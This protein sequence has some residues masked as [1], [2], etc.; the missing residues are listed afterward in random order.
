M[1]PQ[2]D[3]PIVVGAG[4]FVKG[5]RT[6][7]RAD[8]KPKCHGSTLECTTPHCQE[9]I[10]AYDAHLDWRDKELAACLEMKENSFAAWRLQHG[11]PPKPGKIAYHLKRPQWSRHSP[12]EIQRRMECYH[13]H[14]EWTDR[15]MAN[16]LGIT[17]SN[18][19]DFRVHHG[20]PP[21]KRRGER[22]EG[23]RLDASE[24][25][26]RIATYN[27]LRGRAKESD[28]ARELDMSLEAYTVWRRTR[29]LP[30]TSTSPASP[31]A[32]AVRGTSDALTRTIQSLE[33]YLATSTD[34]ESAQRLDIQPKTFRAWRLRAGLPARNCGRRAQT[35]GAPIALAQLEVA[36]RELQ[37]RNLADAS[38]RHTSTTRHA[39][40]TRAA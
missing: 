37:K 14:P 27:R 23:P 35:H 21:H 15:Q 22:P 17:R 8:A 20:L 34:E 18:I 26:R 12:E 24:E 39:I 33:A 19:R 25:G 30:P 13:D 29:N 1:A 2:P 3:T 7:P 9:R 38:A 16:H 36:R 6:R 4:R 40:V 32:R 28:A 31:A 11:L 10:R 5:T